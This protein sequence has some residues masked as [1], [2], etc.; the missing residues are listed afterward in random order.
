MIGKLQ[1]GLGEFLM[2]AELHMH[3]M[4]AS[5]LVVLHMSTGEYVFYRIASS[6]IMMA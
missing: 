3:Q 6:G 1:K 4:N 5:T 2:N